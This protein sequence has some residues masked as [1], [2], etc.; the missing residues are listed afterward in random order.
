MH[1]DRERVAHG[2]GAVVQRQQNFEA[3][4]PKEQKLLTPNDRSAERQMRRT[5]FAKT[6]LSQQEYFRG[7][8]S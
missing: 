3:G 6:G 2:M 5:S 7:S 8:Q 4:S 1:T